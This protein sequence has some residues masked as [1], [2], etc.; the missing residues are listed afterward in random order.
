[1]RVI[2]RIMLLYIQC[3]AAR[4]ELDRN[5]RKM[6]ERKT[7]K[8]AG[9]GKASGSP[10]EKAGRGRRVL[11]YTAKVVAPV[12]VLAVAA[13]SFIGLKATK[14][15]VP[16]RP[17]REQI[18]P[19]AAQPATFDDFQPTIRLYGNIIAGR[20]VDLRALVSGEIVEIGPG[21]K[22]GGLVSKGDL[23]LKVDPFQYEGAVIEAEA[24]LAEARARH[25]EIEAA[26]ASE[27]DALKRTREQL[28]IAKRDLE[29]ALPLAKRG[30][31]SE[32]T[33]DERRLTVSEREQQVELRTNNLA[34]Q[35]AK[36]DQQKAIIS[37]LE[38]R[39]RQAER[40]LAD[41]ELKAPFD[42][43][44]DQ[45]SAEVG[46]I[47]SGNDQVATL[48]DRNWLEVRF[49]LTNSQFGRIVANEGS[50]RGR[51]VDV[52]WHIGDQPARYTA[53][54]ERVAAEINPETGGVDVYARIDDPRTPI[55]LRPGA[56]VEVLMSDRVYSN[57]VRLPQTALYGGD[58]VYVV[59][60]GRLTSRKVDLVGASG[61]DILVRG[62]LKAGE[63]VMITRLSKAE[64]GLRVEE[65]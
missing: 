22:N 4:V 63:H 36:A 40:N 8:S 15:D 39:V 27:R 45:V 65:R 58:T 7:R 43:Y 23:L 62:D 30:T 33:A 19:V 41:T 59:D 10:P 14:P 31:V 50:V 56:F 53:R 3:P 20:R 25:R 47:V 44:V 16:Q 32:K 46:R 35:Q 37:Q 51:R 12:L 29:R 21:L 52:L 11:G 57:V 54:I 18:W 6:A 24:G 9:R 64:S 49:T 17:V 55:H 1:M 38:W 42:A 13:V 61:T 5:F 26:I 28:A 34:V 2:P 48:F 60:A